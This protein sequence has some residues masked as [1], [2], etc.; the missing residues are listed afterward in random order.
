MERSDFEEE[1]SDNEETAAELP[2]LPNLIGTRIVENLKFLKRLW[3]CSSEKCRWR[4]LKRTTKVELLAVVEASANILRPHCFYLTEAQKTRLQ[5][6]A[7]TI[8]TLSRKRTEKGAR[9]FV[10]QRGNGPFFAALLAPLI[11]EASR[12]ILTNLVTANNG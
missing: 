8:R 10:I 11:A 12:Q 7:D 9:R 5:P 3:R 2:T 6:Y 4:L 1:Y